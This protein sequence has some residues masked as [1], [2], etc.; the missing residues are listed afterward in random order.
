M[1]KKK[2]KTETRDKSQDPLP[3]TF[4][5]GVWVYGPFRNRDMLSFTHKF[6]SIKCT[7]EIQ[8]TTTKFLQNSTKYFGVTKKFP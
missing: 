4:Y 7:K 5:M 6:S 3:P 1:F 8:C 2:K